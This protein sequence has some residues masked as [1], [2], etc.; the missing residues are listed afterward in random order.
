MSKGSEAVRTQRRR[1]A[2]YMILRELVT[3]EQHEQAFIYSID[4][5]NLCHDFHSR[6]NPEI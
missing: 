3:I 5:K 2:T 4:K 1:E 6:R